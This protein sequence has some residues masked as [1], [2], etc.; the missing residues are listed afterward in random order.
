[1]HGLAPGY[2]SIDQKLLVFPVPVWLSPPTE[3]SQ[4]EQLPPAATVIYH[5]K[6]TQTP[7]NNTT[8]LMFDTM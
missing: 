6:S 2:L 8:L 1:M 4:L 3:L 7:T 5:N